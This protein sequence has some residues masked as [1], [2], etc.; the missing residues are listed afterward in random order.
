VKLGSKS[1]FTFGSDESTA[2][3]KVGNGMGVRNSIRTGNAGKQNCQ[4]GEF[5]KPTGPPVTSFHMLDPL[6]WMDQ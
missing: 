2:K 3:Q 4:D 5:W 1:C 6:Y